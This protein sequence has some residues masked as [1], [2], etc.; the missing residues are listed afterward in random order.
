MVRRAWLF[1][2]AGLALFVAALWLLSGILLPFVAGCGIAYFLA[3]A[4]DRLERLRLPRG[5]AAAAVLL[6]F[7]V[8]LGA[9]LLLLLPV[10]ELEAA[11]LARRAP[12]VVEL[13][14]QQLQALLELAQ[15][16]L[17]PEDL[18]KLKDMAGGMS[19]AAIGWAA[20]L[21]QRL[22][23]SG[24]ALANLLSLV[25]VTPVVAFFLL[26]DWSLIV[27]EIDHWLPRRH[28]ETIRAEARLI[29]AT[30]AGFVHGQFLVGIVLAVYYGTALTLAGL[31]FAV[32]LGILIGV[33]SFVPMIGILTGLFLATGLGLIQFGATAKLLV[34]LAIFAAGIFVD[35]NLLSPR[36]VGQRVNLHPVWIIFALFAFGSLFGFIGVLL[37][38]PAAAVIG[39]LIRFAIALYLESPLYN[40]DR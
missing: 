20:Q 3:P 4:V 35:S 27:A 24:L 33:L 36:L 14:R 1:W 10:V 23:T 2:I 25:I 30:L 8:A 32:V 11:E 9:I 28:A 40:P 34:I 15:Q 16:R 7:F 26:R 17:S 38:V 19:T 6:V 13:G 29:D 12:D 22:L 39:V 5:L 31:N 21:T 37:A 18:T